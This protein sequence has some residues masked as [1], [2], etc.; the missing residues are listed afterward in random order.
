MS[1][2]QLTEVETTEV[3]STELVV[4]GWEPGSR[5]ALRS[6]THPHTINELIGSIEGMGGEILDVRWQVNSGIS[7]FM[8]A[9]RPV[10]NEV[11][12]GDGGR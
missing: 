4:G 12:D 9:Y 8:V 3:E 1:D 5:I 11:I 10:E 7:H 2:H 6:A